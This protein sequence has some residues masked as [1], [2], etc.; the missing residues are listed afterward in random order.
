MDEYAPFIDRSI[1]GIYSKGNELHTTIHAGH[2]NG[3]TLKELV[4]LSSTLDATASALAAQC[5]IPF[6]SS[7]IEV[8][9]NIHSPGL[10]EFI[11]YAAGGT[12]VLSLLAFSINN[13]I[14]GGTFNMTFKRDGKTK[15]I[16]FSVSSESKGIRGND[17][18]DKQIELESKSELLQ[19]VK[20]LDIKTP[21][22]V[23]AIINGDKITPDMISEAQETKNSPI[24]PE[25][26]M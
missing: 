25:D 2:P 26:S 7:E 10:I 22:I 14:N 19:L 1:W 9:L 18:K 3:L 12:M 15:D 16:N 24:K 6:D 23:S 17:Q 4:K 8:K 5:D 21:D 13:L 20:D 11:S